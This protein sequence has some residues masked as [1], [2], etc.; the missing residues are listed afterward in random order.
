VIESDG[1]G[2]YEVKTVKNGGT[3]S[4]AKS[5]LML[6]MTRANSFI[7]NNK[8]EAKRNDT[9][10]RQEIATANSLFFG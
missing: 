10:N 3:L 1:Y 6:R 5:L 9:P 8:K 7:L 4:Q 2:S